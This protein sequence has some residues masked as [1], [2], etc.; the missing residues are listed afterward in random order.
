MGQE[1]DRVNPLEVLDIPLVECLA[2]LEK[3]GNP[4]LSKDGGTWYCGIN[5]FVHGKGTEFKVRSDFTHKTHFAAANLCYSRLLAELK[6]I[7]ETT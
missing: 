2:E 6:R 1:I 7:K 3:Y 5:V 4:K